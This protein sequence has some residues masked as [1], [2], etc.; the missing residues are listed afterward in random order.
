MAARG[1]DGTDAVELRPP[2]VG[3]V[4]SKLLVRPH[5][6]GISCVVTGDGDS[7]SADQVEPWHSAA[8][9]AVSLLGCQDR[10][11]AWEA[12]LGTAPRTAGL[13][14]SGLLGEAEDFGPVHLAPEG[15]CMCE[16]LFTERLGGSG[17]RHSFPLIASGEYT[18]CVW[19]R[20]AQIAELCLRRACALLSLITGTVWIPRSHPTQ[21]TNEAGPLRSRRYSGMSRPCRVSPE[22]AGTVR[23]LRMPSRSDCEAGP[24]RPGRSL[25]TTATWPRLSTRSMKECS[26]NSSTP[27]WLI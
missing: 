9:T 2:L 27:H 10:I 26:W 18:T 21:V 25:P 11:F 23:S 15:A 1:T 13:D 22:P 14:R 16:Q 19:D 4:H 12:I 24:R 6:D 5:A 8:D 17:I 3:P 7:A 20:A